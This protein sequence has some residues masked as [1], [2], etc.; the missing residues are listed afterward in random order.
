MKTTDS[1]GQ[2]SKIDKNT[3]LKGA[4]NAKTDI[5]IDGT[6]EGEVETVGRVIIGKDA[7]VNGKV[8]CANADIEGVFKGNLTVS[9]SLS[10]KAGSNVEG[11]VFIQ[12]LIV[13]SGA[14]FNANCSMHSEEDGVKKLTNTREK[15]A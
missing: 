4:I 14:T 13:E 10:L 11:E 9:G 6:L 7:V 8:L 5:R 3:V 2:Y 1:N 15:T 12:K